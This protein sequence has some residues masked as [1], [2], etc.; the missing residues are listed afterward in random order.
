ML[1]SD[2]P[3]L[4][5]VPENLSVVG[6]A[7]LS[8]EAVASAGGS[9]SLALTS[10]DTKFKTK[11]NGRVVARGKGLALA[12]GDDPYADTFYYAEGFDKVKVK[13]KHKQRKNFA[14]DKIKVIAVDFP[15]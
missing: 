13:T 3:Y 7:L 14:F 5:S 11:A 6:G 8:I 9:D 2:L 12:I 10:T 4:E 1:I 15:D